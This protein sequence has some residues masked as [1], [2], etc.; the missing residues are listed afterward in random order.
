MTSDVR[1]APPLQLIA[2]TGLSG[3][4]TSTLAE[5]VATAIRAP[6]VRTVL[7]HITLSPPDA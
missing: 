7:S 6:N 5:R 2:F 3:T 1:D 4:G